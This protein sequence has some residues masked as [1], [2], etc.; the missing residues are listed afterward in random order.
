MPSPKKKI[1]QTPYGPVQEEILTQHKATP[2][3]DLYR[4]NVPEAYRS[5]VPGFSD[6]EDAAYLLDQWS[7]EGT[8]GGRAL[9]AAAF[10]LPVV[11][12]KALKKLGKFTSEIDWS[13][14]NKAIPENKTLL[15]EYHDIEKAAKKSGT[16]MKNA[17]GTAFKGTPEQFVQQRSNNFK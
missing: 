16:W 6:V 5:W 3:R 10:A 13:K 17:D 4:N 9:S 11:G 8:W 7:P 14:W 1:Y 15:K 12:S 2:L